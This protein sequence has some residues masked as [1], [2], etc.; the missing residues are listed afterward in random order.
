MDDP[1]ILII[2][3]YLDPKKLV[4][5]TDI[6]IFSAPKILS[7]FRGCV[8]DSKEGRFGQTNFVRDEKDSRYI[9]LG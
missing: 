2:P 3:L 1:R 8:V 7:L 9:K 6:E 4:E 5:T